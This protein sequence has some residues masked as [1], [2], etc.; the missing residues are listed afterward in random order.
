V[1]VK[2]NKMVKFLIVRFSSIGDIVLTTPVMRCLKKQVEGAEIHY[3]TKSKYSSILQANPY[4]DKIHELNKDYQALLNELRGEGIDY[5]IDLHRNLRTLRLKLSLKRLSYSFN[6]LNFRKWLF[7][8]FKYNSLP[9]THIVDRYL[10]TTKTFSVED[11]HAGLDYFIPEVD[12]MDLSFMS[13]EHRSNFIV[14]VIGG[15]HQTKQIPTER[16]RQLINELDIPI[17]FLGGSEDIG[18]AEELMSTIEKRAVY[19]LTGK[20]SINQ[21]ASIVKQAQLIIT[22]DTGLMHIAA[23]FK[24]DIFSVWGNTVPAFGMYAY[25]SG[26]HSKIFEVKGLNCRPCTK[27][28]FPRCPKGH[29]DCMLKQDL[30]AISRETKK[31]ITA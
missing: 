24:K 18:K 21:S 31:L 23:A 11:D 15:G 20:L 28:G 26:M 25:K 29:F 27:I 2:E 30:A 9:P 19:N 16:I 4:I 12:E 5:I 14:I 7:V 6:K 13:E 10:A 8:N 22:P 3:L 17:V 1:S